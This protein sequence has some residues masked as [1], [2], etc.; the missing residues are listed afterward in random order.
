[1]SNKLTLDI[2]DRLIL[3]TLERQNLNEAEYVSGSKELSRRSAPSSA[4]AHFVKSA[5]IEKGTPEDVIEVFQKMKDLIEDPENVKFGAGRLS[6]MEAKFKRMVV[7][8][9]FH[10]LCLNTIERTERVPLDYM[11]AGFGMEVLFTTVMGG[12]RVDGKVEDVIVGSDHYSLKFIGKN[13]D[14]TQS[15][16]FLERTEGKDIAYVIFRKVAE[17]GNIGFD[18]YSG[19]LLQEKLETIYAAKDNPEDAE[20]IFKKGNVRV[21]GGKDVIVFTTKE[22]DNAAAFGTVSDEKVLQGPLQIR[23]PADLSAFMDIALSTMGDQVKTLYTSLSR[24]KES[25]NAFY[26][27]RGGE[28]EE[29]LNEATRN[30]INVNERYKEAMPVDESLSLFESK[31]KNSKKD[32][33]KLIEE[34]ILNKNK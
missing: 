33:D 10:K 17:G 25:L 6:T 7:L 29:N 19:W 8:E 28:K 16:D 20:E 22:L 18:L 34:V 1:M 32:L 13:T 23:M 30:L 15:L 12:Q 11:Q 14:V 27:T 5:L 21:K 24:F 2:I 31:Q 4:R 3:E 26:A 9:S